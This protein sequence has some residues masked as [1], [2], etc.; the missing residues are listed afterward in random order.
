[1]EKFQS[2]CQFSIMNDDINVDELLMMWKKKEIRICSWNPVENVV[3]F[4]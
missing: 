1:M 4:P 3:F 2:I